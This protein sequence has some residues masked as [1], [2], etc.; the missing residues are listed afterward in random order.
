MK[1]IILLVSRRYRSPHWIMLEAI[2]QYGER[3]QRR[4]VS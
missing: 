3:E 4:Q 2:R 1:D